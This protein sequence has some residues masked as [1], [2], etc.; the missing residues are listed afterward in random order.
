MQP[1]DLPSYKEVLGS[2]GY[3][4]QGPVCCLEGSNSNPWRDPGAP[5]SRA[6]DPLRHK[7]VSEM[8]KKVNDHFSGCTQDRVTTV[9]TVEALIRSPVVLAGCSR[10][11]RLLGGASLEE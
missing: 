4:L 11:R 2:G 5:F 10:H 9:C 1:G 6:T 7:P 3:S 8:W